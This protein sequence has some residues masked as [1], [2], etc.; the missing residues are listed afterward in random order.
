MVNISQITPTL[1][2][3]QVEYNSQDENLISSFEIDTKLD[4]T[5]YIEYSIYDLN[6]NLL[7]INSNY[8]SYTILDDGQ[9]SLSSDINKINIDPQTDLEGIGY[10]QGKYNV[11]YNILSKKIGSNLETLYISEISSD[12]TEIRLE[13]NN[14]ENTSLR[15]QTQTFFLEREYS[16]YFLDFYI[17][18]G[19]N[20]LII[21][22]NIV[23]SETDPLNPTIL[24]KLYK[25]LPDNYDVKSELWVV[26]LI[27][28]PLAYNIEFIE[29]PIIIEDSL[30]LQGPNF[31]LELKDQVNN[32]TLNLS[33]SDIVKTSLSSSTNQINSLLNKKE[34]SVNID[35]SNFSNFIHL[36]SAKTRLENFTYKVNL[37]EQ[38]SASI[39]TIESSITGPTSASSVAVGSTTIFKNKINDIITNFDHYE[40][41]LYYESSSYAWPKTTSSPPYL[42]TKV[43]SSEAVSWL[44][45]AD[46]TSTDFG[47]IALSASRFDDENKDNLTFSIPSYLKDNPDNRQYELFID[48]VAQHYDNIWIYI[49]DVT[50][51]FNS[52][53]RLDYGVSK[54]LVADAIKDFGVK[55]YQ[56]NFSNDDLFTAFLGLT[57]EGSL[58]PFPNIVT[59]FLTQ[60]G[61][62]VYG[63]D[64][65]GGS[66]PSTLPTVPTGFEYIDTLISAS[67]DPIPQNDVNKSLYKRLYHNL[68]YLL[69]AKGT[70]PGLRAL[71]TSYGIPDT[72]L[73]ISEF[74]G[75]DKVNSNDWDLYSN[76]FNYAFNNNGNNFISSSFILNNSWTGEILNTNLTSSNPSTVEFRFKSN[77]TIPSNVSQSIFSIYSA[78]ILQSDLVLEYTGSGLTSA[79]YSGAIIDPNYQYATLKWIPDVIAGNSA[80]I[81]LPF[82]N[83][84]WWSVMITSGSTNG[85]ELTSANKLYNGDTGTSIGFISSSFIAT[86]SWSQTT[87]AFFTTSSS[88]T[89]FSGSLQEIRYYNTILNKD[90]FK[91]YVMN[92][93]SI[94][95]NTVNSS[96]NELAFRASLGSELD[97]TSTTSTHPKIIGSFSSLTSSFSGSSNSNFNFKSTP[98]YKANTE[99]FFQDQPAVGI[100]N[101]ITDKI[102]IEDNVLPTGNTLSAFQSLQ[103][104]PTVS[105]SYT[106]NVNYLEVAFSPQNEINDDI[107]N[108]LGYFSIGDYIGDPSFRTNSNT[109]YPDLNLLR[110][111]YFKKYTKSYNL[112]DFIRLIKYFDNS[113]FK[114]IKD[115]VPARTSLASGIVIKQH[116][117]ERNRY[118]SPSVSTNS[119]IAKYGQSGSIHWNQPLT[120]QNIAVSGTVKPQWNGFKEGRISNASGGP[121]GSFSI[122][123][124]INTT[125]YG[126]DGTGPKNRFNITQSWD[127]TYPTLSGSA[128]YVQDTQDEFY[129][130]EFTGSK[131]T[132]T[133]QNLNP[134]CDPFKKVNPKGL[135]YTGIRIYSQSSSSPIYNDFNHY[136]NADN[137]PTNGYISIWYHQDTDAQGELIGPKYNQSSLTTKIYKSATPST[138]KKK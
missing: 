100:K 135:D 29:E 111:E 26:T 7:N 62:G 47:G 117:L 32:S 57:P 8:N 58:F 133:T 85:F 60:Y 118:K 45:S 113:L 44:G 132:V 19:N 96:P 80:S 1:I 70:I 131:I 138:R 92:P 66:S 17:N 134:G 84:D 38:H 52:D 106:P 72:I 90:S 5:G 41:I 110:D 21:A 89:A 18:F 129:D 114:M 76:N 87:D 22:N 86:G 12:R 6:N 136:I 102:R 30:P 105:S 54:D 125:P 107:N 67:N 43:A 25:P 120:F 126:P 122:F 77:E 33:H 27:D 4:S 39:S 16:E 64:P 116:L 75:K 55:L 51:K 69:K 103:Q 3:N 2:D 50:E 112:F 79:S 130:G 97:I 83:K 119:I 137:L 31:N 36:S 123:N 124:S 109:S 108:Q 73:K 91:D 56:N 10:S 37:L 23:L 81:S 40:Y 9:S 95:G 127:E 15:E 11:Y 28:N 68:P 88:Q 82:F 46:E 115:F 24:V 78:S 65:Y 48:M 20:N 42:L 71:I 63:I 99:Y 13:S 121:G 93:L 128:L 53:N 101:R 34:I 104:T 35:Y 74:G 98:T 61:F 14:L 59:P 49:K 94:E